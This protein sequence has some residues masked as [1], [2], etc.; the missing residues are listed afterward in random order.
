MQHQTEHAHCKD[1]RMLGPLIGAAVACAAD[2]KLGTIT[3]IEDERDA[4]RLS[5]LATFN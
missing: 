5:A 4:V 2:T 3:A 1:D